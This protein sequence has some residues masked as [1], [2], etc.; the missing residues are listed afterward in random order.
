[1]RFTEFLKED[2]EGN[3]EL[4]LETLVG[5]PA[6]LV[7]KHNQGKNDKT[8]INVST[9]TALPPAYDKLEIENVEYFGDGGLRPCINSKVT[10]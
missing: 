10:D 5:T 9:I 2:K 1:M 3:I 8:Y 7:L 6:M 4:D